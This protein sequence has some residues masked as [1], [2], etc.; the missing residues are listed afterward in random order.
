M[1]RVV[2][3]YIIFIALVLPVII[4]G[5][6]GFILWWILPSGEGGYRGGLGPSVRDV[7]IWDRHAWIDIHNVSALVL[8]VL[9]IIHIVIHWRWIVT[10]T[11]RMFT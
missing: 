8:V 5:I 3:N 11:K 6:S 9:V 2:K 10:V 1:N 4:E 7:F